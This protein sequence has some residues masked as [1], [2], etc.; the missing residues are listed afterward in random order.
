MSRSQAIGVTPVVG[1]GTSK[2]SRAVRLFGRD[3]ARHGVHGALSGAG[4]SRQPDPLD[5]GGGRKDHPTTSKALDDGPRDRKA[6]V[7]RP[8]GLRRLV[9]GEGEVARLEPAQRKV[10][11]D[12]PPVLEPGLGPNRIGGEQL[13]RHAKLVGQIGDELAR[14]RGV[15]P[16][17]KPGCRSRASQVAAPSRFASLRRAP[18]KSRSSGPSV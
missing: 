11:R 8:G 7:G 10:G 2:A 3:G 9:Q 17:P 16:E 1:S 15:M 18:R 4:P 12:L 6:M 14:R 5:A 13:L